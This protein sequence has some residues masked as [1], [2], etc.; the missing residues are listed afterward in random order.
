MHV[1]RTYMCRTYTYVHMHINICIFTCNP[2][3]YVYMFTNCYRNHATLPIIVMCIFTSCQFK[4]QIRCPPFLPELTSNKFAVWFR[5]KFWITSGVPLSMKFEPN[6]ILS[7]PHALT[8][9]ESTDFFPP[10][11]TVRLT[12]ICSTLVDVLFTQEAS[13]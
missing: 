11:W 5:Q 8:S 3:M 6:L 13:V 7:T 4:L 12:C 1:I 10:N 2:S 9:L